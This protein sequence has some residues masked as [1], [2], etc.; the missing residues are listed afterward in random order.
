MLSIV[1]QRR[2]TPVPPVTNQGLFLALAAIML[3]TVLSRSAMTL[4]TALSSTLMTTDTG[5]REGKS[6][7]LWKT[8]ASL[9]EEQV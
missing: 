2:T 1:G 8:S 6:G 4:V 5:E 3:V 9:E 7:I